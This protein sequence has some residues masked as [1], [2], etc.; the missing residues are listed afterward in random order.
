MDLHQPV[1]VSVVEGLRG[2]PQNGAAD[3]VNRNDG[4]LERVE[5]LADAVAGLCV[6]PAQGVEGHDCPLDTG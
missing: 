5:E 1:E 2:R 3:R 4:V 6:G